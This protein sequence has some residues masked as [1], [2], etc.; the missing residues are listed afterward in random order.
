MSDL[1]LPL[2]ILALLFVLLMLIRMRLTTP[3]RGRAT[4]Q[5]LAEAEAKIASAVSDAA[6]AL[7]LCEAAEACVRRLSRNERAVSYFMKA[8]KAD[9][10]SA[11]VVER[12]VQA[13]DHRPRALEAVLWR[14]LAITEWG[15]QNRAATTVA[16][17]ALAGLYATKLRNPTRG[18]ALT[19]ATALLA[20]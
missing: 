15:N 7:A 18:K 11:E 12:V 4:R 17:R 16:L 3:K 1:K 13:L 5:A 19:R 14:R 10:A 2:V 9:S 8:M 6:R 20:L